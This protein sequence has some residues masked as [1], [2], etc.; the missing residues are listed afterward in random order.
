MSVD[1]SNWGHNR[2][3]IRMPAADSRRETLRGSFFAVNPIGDTR[4]AN[5][6]PGKRQTELTVKRPLDFGDSLT[7]PDVGL[8]H[9]RVVSREMAHDRFTMHPKRSAVS[10]CA[11][12]TRSSPRQLRGNG[13]HPPKDT[14]INAA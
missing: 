14:R 7:M 10:R 12:S 9:V 1:S 4:S 5:G 6:V 8:P 2:F 11:N 3:A 13:R